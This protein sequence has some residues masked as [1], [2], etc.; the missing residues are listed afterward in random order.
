MTGIPLLRD[1]GIP[2]LRETGIPL[3]RETGIP[4]LRE[5]GIPLLRDTSH[6]HVNTGVAEN[7]HSS[8]IKYV[9]VRYCISLDVWKTL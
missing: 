5:T 9:V 8:K 2:L 4:M 6:Y 3:L 1:T 7:I